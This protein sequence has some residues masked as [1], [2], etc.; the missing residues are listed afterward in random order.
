VKTLLRG[1]LPRQLKRHRILRGPLRGRFMVTSWHH[2]FTSLTGGTEPDVISWFN[3]RVKPGETW[4]DIGA[5]YGYTAMSLAIL[6]GLAGRVFAFEPK[7]ETCGCLA[8]S[9]RANGF[10]QITVVPMALG[11]VDQMEIQRFRTEGS[12]AVGAGISDGPAETVV[13][14]EFDWLW[15]RISGGDLRIDGIKIDVQ[16][17]E[18]EV[19]RGMTR[20]LKACTP[21]LIVELHA[22]VDRTAMLDLL[23]SCGYERGGTPVFAR[24]DPRDPL[25]VDNQS[26]A[27]TARR[28]HLAVHA[29]P[30][31]VLSNG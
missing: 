15:P 23:E 29:E 20:F 19:L 31:V 26:Y 3:A 17:M 14:S 4:L 10:D 8:Q 2:N 1:L 24:V 18:L 5:N 9:V 27:F 28:S 12:M 22:G 7:F 11:A 25:R 6:V 13:V 30:A 16:G 21:K